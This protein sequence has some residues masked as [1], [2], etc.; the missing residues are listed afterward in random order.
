MAFIVNNLGTII[1]GAVL[2][3]IVGLIIASTVKRKKR[4]QSTCGCECSG[5]PSASVCHKQEP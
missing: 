1:V 3:V 5:C 2:L 4:G